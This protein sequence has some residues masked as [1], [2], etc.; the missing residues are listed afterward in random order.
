MHEQL[1]R[2]DTEYLMEVK[3]SFPK[4]AILARCLLNK[5]IYLAADKDKV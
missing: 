4:G 2:G 1:S 3:T 5:A